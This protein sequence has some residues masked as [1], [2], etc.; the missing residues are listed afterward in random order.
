M[1]KF[2]HEDLVSDIAGLI[3][4]EESDTVIFKD[5]EIEYENCTAVITGKVNSY[6]NTQGG[7]TFDEIYLESVILQFEDGPDTIFNGDEIKRL[8]NDIKFY[9]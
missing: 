7:L 5:T 8:E 4:F 6:E 1:K 2:T 3:S 9:I